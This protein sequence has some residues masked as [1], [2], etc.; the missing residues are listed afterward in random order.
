[1]YISDMSDAAL[2]DL[3]TS[4]RQLVRFPLNRIG[5]DIA[6]GD[7]HGCF[8]ELQKALRA[9]DFNPIRDRLFSVGDLVDRGPESHR[10]LEWLDK[11]WFHAICGNHEQLVCRTASGNPMPDVDHMKHGGDWMLGMSESELNAIVDRLSALP[12][13][14]T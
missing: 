2:S 14:S 7:I 3:S 10:V 13:A 5:R 11:P 4:S 8:S 9:I 1:M 12:I 6:V